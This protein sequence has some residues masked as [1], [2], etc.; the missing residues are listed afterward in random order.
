MWYRFV[1]SRT[2]TTHQ[3]LNQTPLL[4]FNGRRPQPQ[5]RQFISDS[6]DKLQTVPVFR[7]GLRWWERERHMQRVRRR[8]ADESQAVVRNRLRT[9]L[10][11]QFCGPPLTIWWHLAELL[12]SISLFNFIYACLR[13]KYVYV[14][15]HNGIWICAMDKY[16]QPR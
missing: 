10:T 16:L 6:H 2:P 8:R 7:V 13:Q 4:P 1:V 15:S 11:M 14:Y 12:F 9:Q 3:L 5:T